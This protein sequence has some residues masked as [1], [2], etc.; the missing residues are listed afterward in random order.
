[1]KEGYMLAYAA[2][3]PAVAVRQSSPNALL[4]VIAAHVAA[5]AAVMSVKMDLPRRI[6]PP[7]IVTS[8]PL[9][10]VPKPN[11]VPLPTA[12]HTTNLDRPT[13]VPTD[14]DI[15][16]VDTGGIS[17]QPDMAAGGSARPVA[18]PIPPLRPIIARSGPQLLTSAA[19]LK[20][21]YPQ[22]KLLTEEEAVLR[23]RLTIDERGRVVAV[24]PVGKA[25][26]VFLGAARRHLI[27]H[28]RF[29]P[30]SEDGRA[31]SSSTVIMLRFQLDG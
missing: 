21:P 5:V 13:V 4:F 27:A 30:A 18:D 6:F 11:P 29:R 28:W 24:D 14:V 10:P 20:P 23:L 17:S 8:I 26:D 15:Q 9:P 1:M 2:N 7:T 31:V 22:S 12:T 19:E 25:D 3:R 16:R